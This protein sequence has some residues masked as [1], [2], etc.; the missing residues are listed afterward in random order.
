VFNY[1]EATCI[2]TGWLTGIIF[3]NKPWGHPVFRSWISFHSL[4]AA[5]LFILTHVLFID[6]WR[7]YSIID[8]GN[9]NKF[10]IWLH[11]AVLSVCYIGFL[12][13]RVILINH[14]QDLS[15]LL[16]ELCNHRS[17]RQDLKWTRY[18]RLVM[19]SIVISSCL[20]LA[21][22]VS[23]GIIGIYMGRLL[24]GASWFSELGT[25]FY[26]LLITVFGYFISM[27]PSN[28]L[29]VLIILI[30]SHVG[31]KFDDFCDDLEAELGTDCRLFEQNHSFPM[32]K[33]KSQ[34]NID[35]SKR[36]EL[37][38]RLDDIENLFEMSSRIVS[39]LALCL[40]SVAGFRIVTDTYA[41]LYLSMDLANNF[42][43]FG[44]GCFGIG[45]QVIHLGLILVGQHI[46]N[47]VNLK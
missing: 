15:T 4:W 26:G 23:F 27:S 7:Q 39:P 47:V 11:K 21:S 37:I 24:L 25:F 46:E 19:L 43:R 22:T 28:V 6:V 13:V 44:E 40:I 36:N 41:I 38:K 1:L 29:F 31:M 42:L 32:S 34:F 5:I 20:L 2:W 35:A 8:G 18:W 33:S 17:C 3:L 45:E 10:L 30:A 12:W 16:N 9:M 14:A